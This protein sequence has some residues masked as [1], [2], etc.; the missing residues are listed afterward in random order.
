MPVRLAAC[1][2]CKIAKVSCDHVTP[3]GRCRERNPADCTYRERPFK[4]R[5][6]QQQNILEDSVTAIES[7]TTI[8][9]TINVYPNPGYQGTSSHTSIFDQVKASGGAINDL[10][11]TEITTPDGAAGDPQDYEAAGHIKLLEAIKQLDVN[12]SAELIT[13]WTSQ[14]V[15]LA[16]AG[17]LVGSCVES[18][19]T[20]FSTSSGIVSLAATLFRNS[21]QELPSPGTMTISAFCQS[22]CDS[23]WATMG[24]FLVALSRAV[25]DTNSF[26]RL[27]NTRGGQQKLQKAALQQAD[28]CLETCLSLDC[29][30]DLQLIL[31][32][33]SFIAH[34]MIDGDQSE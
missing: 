13:Q 19:I 1:N 30:N 21:R 2:P 32:Y 27:Y 8:P 34:S 33:E 9:V 16:L 15:N 23:G 22:F 31:Q 18:T 6:V 17:P 25:E 28:Q 7:S 12:A 24:I 4:K 20:F 29:L 26:P 14:G 10:F 3:C 5:R 11:P